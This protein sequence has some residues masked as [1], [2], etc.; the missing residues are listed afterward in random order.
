MRNEKFLVQFIS[1]LTKQDLFIVAWVLFGIA[2]FIY[3]L[4]NDYR[5][6]NR[7]NFKESRKSQ[8]TSKNESVTVQEPEGRNRPVDK[9]E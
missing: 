2:P 9:G 8:I 3:L 7:R 1:H 6:V 5:K 4:W